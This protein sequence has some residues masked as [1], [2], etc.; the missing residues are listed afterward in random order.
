MPKD[1]ALDFV[2]R[3]FVDDGAGGWLETNDS[4]T[5]VLFQLE[6][7]R[8]RWPGD[9]RAGSRIR[10]LLEREEPASAAELRD[11]ALEALQELVD[12]QVIAALEVALDTDQAGRPVFVLNYFDPLTGSPVDVA[13]SP[14]G[15]SP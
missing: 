2:T 12:E 6:S 1:T 8:G 5:A 13:Y 14:W 9:P 15:G 4:R 7:R 10:E 11:A 3:D